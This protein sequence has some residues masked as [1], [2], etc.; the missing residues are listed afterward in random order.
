[1]GPPVVGVVVATVGASPT[2]VPLVTSV[3]QVVL[4]VTPSIV[5]D[6]AHTGIS[7][8]EVEL[9]IQVNQWSFEQ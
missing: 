2:H 7:S 3:V 9:S 1:V 5:K 4:T 8:R 6:M